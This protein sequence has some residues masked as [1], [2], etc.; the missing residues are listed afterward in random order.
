MKYQYRFLS[1][2]LSMWI[3]MSVAI[4][5]YEIV[6][7]VIS[8]VPLNFFEVILAVIS[9]SA[10]FNLFLTTYVIKIH[11]F[12]EIDDKF[13]WTD[14]FGRKFEIK[15]S[16][17]SKYE[18]KSLLNSFKYLR[19]ESPNRTCLIPLFFKKNADVLACFQKKAGPGMSRV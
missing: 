2:Y 8:D 19:V 3:V 10:V 9:F 4:L 12:Q 15:F 11:S 16:E 6:D 18:V 13:R 7:R 17:V 14:L 1:I 5:S